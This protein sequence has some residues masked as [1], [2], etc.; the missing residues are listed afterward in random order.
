MS[1]T[2]RASTGEI[3]VV[4]R[5][6]LD[7]EGAPAASPIPTLFVACAEDG[8]FATRHFDIFRLGGPSKP[9]RPSLPFFL[10][11]PRLT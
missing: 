10:T 2:L 9:G 5:V 3:A 4:G 1:T 11:L 8:H 7:A 6:G